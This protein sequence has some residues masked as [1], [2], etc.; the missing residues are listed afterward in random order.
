ML[1][2]CLRK[3]SPRLPCI[4]ASSL[5]TSNPLTTTSNSPDIVISPRIERGPTDILEALASTVGKDYTAPHYR[6][7]DD[8]WLIP[9]KTNNKRDFTLSQEAGRNAAKYILNAHPDLFE[10]NRIVAEPPI[11]AFQPRAA[12]NR[13][14][15]T[16]ELL[17]NL[18]SNVQVLDS[19]E[20]Y[21]LLKEKGKEIPGDLRQR[22]LEL[23]AFHNEC[24]VEEEVLE[25]KGMINDQ[26]K[27]KWKNGGFVEQLYSEGGEATASERVILLAGLG[28]YSGGQKVWQ[29]YNECKANNDKVPVEGYNGIISRID[30]KDGV[31]QAIMSVKETLSEMKEAGVV[32]N[33][34]T[35]LSILELLATIGKT[36]D[37]DACCRH[38]LDVLAEFRVLGVEFSL[39]V[40]KSLLDIYVDKKN[41]GKSPI[42][43]DIMKEL[44]G[45]D[46]SMAK[47]PQDLWFLPRAMQVCSQMNN[48]KLA[49]V[50]NEFLHTGQNARLLSDFKM[51]QQYYQNFLTVILHNDDFNTAMEL[52]NKMVPNTFCPVYHFY[53][54]ML[55]HLHTNGAMQHLSKI[56]DD[57]VVSD[58]AS[59]N[60]ENM[61]VLINQVMQ[62]LKANDTSTFDFTGLSQVWLDIAKKCF[63]NIV[64]KK[65][66]RQM[67]LRFN[68][69]APNICD[70]V[71]SVALREGS[72]ELAASV[73]EFC[74]EEKTVM[75]GNLS[76]GVLSDFINSSCVLNESDKAVDGVEYALDVGSSKALKMGMLVA[77]LELR[78]DQRSHL[79]KVFTTQTGWVNI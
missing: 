34:G 37:Q 55:N 56:W 6:Y 31:E 69:L 11:T 51:E 39:G 38:A 66:D 68:T 16:M 22:L 5:S 12:Y 20:V 63:D 40:Y 49:W 79:N 54:L 28:K 19:M 41:S 13:D 73:V 8:P 65:A 25:S 72:Y 30:K 21:S 9:R 10:Q 46:M 59:S 76:D 33:V 14:N 71:V 61:Y 53:E 57:I 50:V 32:P 18:V 1:S 45:K 64:E 75:A 36:R 52:Y 47:D 4:Y 2:I 15:V 67:Y 7:H 60:R 35:L 74:R 17:D 62:I 24:E 44:E 26:E 3:T 27:N 43:F 29:V 78:D 58:Y 48:A 42:L 70:L 23:V 77:K